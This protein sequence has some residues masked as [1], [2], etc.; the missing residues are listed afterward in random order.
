MLPEKPA[1][2]GFP[3]HDLIRRRWSPRAF[4][5]R[6]VEPEKLGSLLEAARW[7]ASSN[8]EQ[9][10]R[11]ILATRENPNDFA[12]LLGC[13]KESNQVWVRHASVLMLSVARLTFTED[14]QPTAMPFTMSDRPSPAWRFKPRRWGL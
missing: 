2:T 8:N 9:P 5:D 10:W 12:R 11:F 3:I 14:G 7:A 13:L 6:H 1:E 4:A